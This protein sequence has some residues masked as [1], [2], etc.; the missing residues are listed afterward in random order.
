MCIHVRIFVLK[1][2]KEEENVVKK[3]VEELTVAIVNLMFTG[4]FVRVMEKGA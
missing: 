2:K 3:K 1:L 4:I